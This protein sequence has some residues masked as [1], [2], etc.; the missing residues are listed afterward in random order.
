MAVAATEAE[1]G[2]FFEFGPF[3]GK[4]GGAECEE[5]DEKKEEKKG[6]VGDH[7]MKRWGRRMGYKRGQGRASYN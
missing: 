1:I 6:V 4:G 3:G 5:E 2:A 7:Y